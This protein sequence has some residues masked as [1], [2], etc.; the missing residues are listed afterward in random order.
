MTLLA[1]QSGKEPVLTEGTIMEVQR[2]EK[3]SS[4]IRDISETRLSD[5]TRIPSE[6]IEFPK[7]KG[8]IGISNS[9]SGEVNFESSERP[10]RRLSCRVIEADFVDD[11]VFINKEAL[12]T[13]L[14]ERLQA[15][16]RH[17][18]SW[19]RFFLSILDLFVHCAES[20]P[21]RNVQ[22]PKNKAQIRIRVQPV[23][24]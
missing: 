5:T 15:W 12:L 7:S 22:S 18:R 21:L 11:N 13:N 19:A 10:A 17:Q 1:V 24:F 2:S 6:L 3:T 14:L 23:Y 4:S 8:L 16:V 9:N 20:K